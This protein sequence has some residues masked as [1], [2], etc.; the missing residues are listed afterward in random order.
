MIRKTNFLFGV[1]LLNYMFDYK[2]T[3]AQTIL[4]FDYS[5]ALNINRMGVEI[6]VTM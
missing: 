3:A 4:V 2:F 5:F 1:I 6:E